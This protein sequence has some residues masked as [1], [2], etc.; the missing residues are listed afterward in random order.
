MVCVENETTVGDSVEIKL[1][2]RIHR[3]TLTQL[4]IKILIKYIF[5]KSLVVLLKIHVSIDRIVGLM[6][7]SL[8]IDNIIVQENQ[9]KSNSGKTCAFQANENFFIFP[10]SMCWS[11]VTAILS[12]NIVIFCPV[13][14]PHSE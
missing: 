14:F 5:G 11:K 2:V 6:N 3:L 10:F 4:M 8:Y 13:V 9:Q 7:A 1:K 12:E